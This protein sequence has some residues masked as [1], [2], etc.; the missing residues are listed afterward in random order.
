MVDCL[1]T[2]QTNL[3]GLGLKCKPFA[4]CRAATYP[5]ARRAPNVG[6]DLHSKDCPLVTWTP[7]G[8]FCPG[9]ASSGSTGIDDAIAK[10]SAPWHTGWPPA[11][12]LIS[13]RRAREAQVHHSHQAAS[14]CWRTRRSRPR[15]PGS[16]CRPDYPKDATLSD[17]GGAQP[18][19]FALHLPV[20]QFRPRVA[21]TRTWCSHAAGKP[22]R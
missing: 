19:D 8:A 11:S 6:T 1:P 17:V 9:P 20:A 12:P 13:V 5:S 3:A 22:A 2:L 16:N 4:A 15:I 14:S 10:R 18:L 7:T 21:V